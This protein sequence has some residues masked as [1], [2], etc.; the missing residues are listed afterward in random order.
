MSACDGRV[1]AVRRSSSRR[2]DRLRAATA[3]VE[4]ANIAK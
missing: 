1:E 3:I 4:I 2:L